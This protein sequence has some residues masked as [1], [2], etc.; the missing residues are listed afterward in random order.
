MELTIPY[1]SVCL[2]H[3]W[4]YRPVVYIYA[5]YTENIH[6]STIYLFQMQQECKILKTIVFGMVQHKT[7]YDVSW[8]SVASGFHSTLEFNTICKYTGCHRRNGANFGRVFL[9]LN[10]TYITQKTYIQSWR[11][12]QIM[13]IEKCGLL[14]CPRTVSRPWRHIHPLRMPGNEKQL[15]NIGMQWRW[16]DNATAEAC[17][18]YLET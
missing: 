4:T 16:R 5:V 8:W 11:V 1:Y 15:A 18:N 3:Q 17:V 13:A 10:Y 9:M 14:W 12:T 6:F 2:Y 7:S